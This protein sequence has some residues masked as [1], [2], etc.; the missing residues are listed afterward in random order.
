MRVE[1][2]E[3]VPK[4]YGWGGWKMPIFHLSDPEY[5]EYGCPVC[6]R[7]R[8]GIPW[9]IAVQKAELALTAGGCPWGRARRRKY[10]VAPNQP[11]PTMTH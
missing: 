6:R 11:I 10:G 1:R 5:C 4:A 8:N 2:K 7:A 3:V 9:A